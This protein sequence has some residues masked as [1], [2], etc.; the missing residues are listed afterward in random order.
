MIKSQMCLDT[1]SWFSQSFPMD[2]RNYRFLILTD[3]T[4]TTSK[5]QTLAQIYVE[6]VDQM[7]SATEFFDN[8]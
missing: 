5:K 2:S 1:E 3:A 4:A 6:F 7:F 8:D